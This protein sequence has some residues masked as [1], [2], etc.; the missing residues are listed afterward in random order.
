[1]TPA[2][3]GPA[4]IAVWFDDA[5]TTDGC[6]LAEFLFWDETQDFMTK[7]FTSAHGAGDM[8]CSPHMTFML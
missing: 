6:V 3:D 1:V 5:A 2:R 8:G 7:E 4:A